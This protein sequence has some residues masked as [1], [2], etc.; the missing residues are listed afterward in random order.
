MASQILKSDC[1]FLT[2]Q[3]ETMMTDPSPST[4]ARI[5]LFINRTTGAML[6]GIGVM[7]LVANVLI[8]CGLLFGGP[9]LIIEFLA[10]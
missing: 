5:M 7:V 10:Q 8:G 9:E 6:A 1:L 3:P 4:I 2:M